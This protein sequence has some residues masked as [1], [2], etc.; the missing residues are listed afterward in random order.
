MRGFSHFATRMYGSF[1]SFHGLTA[2]SFSALRSVPLSGRAAVYA[3]THL[4][5][6]VPAAPTFGR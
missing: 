1:P 4:L 3:P 2:H 5:Q 6:G